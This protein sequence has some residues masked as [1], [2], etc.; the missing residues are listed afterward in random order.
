MGLNYDKVIQNL[1]DLLKLK[2]KIKLSVSIIDLKNNKRDISEFKNKWKKKGINV[3][4]Q[5]F[6]NWG[7]TLKNVLNEMPQNS[8]FRVLTNEVILHDGRVSICCLDIE[9]KVIL[10]NVLNNTL[11]EIWN[12][13]KAKEY[14]ENHLSHKRTKLLVCKDCNL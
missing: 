12:S 13:K 7:G 9:E 11:L 2:K 8:C 10:G 6:L 5:R 14:R 4:V 1:K 3:I